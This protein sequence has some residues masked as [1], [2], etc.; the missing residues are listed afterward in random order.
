MRVYEETAENSRETP[1]K[2]DRN[3]LE[4]KIGCGAP[5]RTVASR[6]GHR[7]GISCGDVRARLDLRQP[8]RK[9]VLAA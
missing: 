9:G 4:V 1:V 7:V 2:L 8:D 5:A 6:A 3:V